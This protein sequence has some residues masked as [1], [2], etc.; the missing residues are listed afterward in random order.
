MCLFVLYMYFYR[1]HSIHSVVIYYSMLL[2]SNGALI[3]SR[4]S[5]SMGIGCPYATTDQ[6]LMIVLS[7][8]C[9]GHTFIWTQNAV[10][11]RLSLP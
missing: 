3:R 6:S 8:Q 4:I 9:K 1:V 11:E 5:E 2:R 7:S 10:N